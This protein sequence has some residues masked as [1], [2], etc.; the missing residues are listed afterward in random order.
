M[1]GAVIKPY[2]LTLGEMGARLE[3]RGTDGRSDAKFFSDYARHK[4]HRHPNPK[5]EGP[6]QSLARNMILDVLADPSRGAVAQIYDAIPE[7]PNREQFRLALLQEL[8]WVARLVNAAI[9]H[10]DHGAAS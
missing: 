2:V 1:V 10:L 3:R 9:K 5:K 7:S 4:R 6:L 8:R